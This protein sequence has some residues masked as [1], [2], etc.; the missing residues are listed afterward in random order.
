[1]KNKEEVIRLSKEMYELTRPKCGECHLPFSCCDKRYCELAIEYAKENW[2]IE[3]APTDNNELPLLGPD[4]CIAAPHLRPVCTV[5]V[6]ER[7]YLSDAEYI[8]KYFDLRDKLSE[9]MSVGM[10]GFEPSL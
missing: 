9:A 5:H 2:G 8:E 10:E 3:L 6:C 1:M 7:S 4:G